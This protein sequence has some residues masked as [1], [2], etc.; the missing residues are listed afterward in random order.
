LCLQVPFRPQHEIATAAEQALAA[1]S[2]ER[3]DY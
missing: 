1:D 3:G 2:V